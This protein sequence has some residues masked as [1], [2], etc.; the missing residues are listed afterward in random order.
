MNTTRLKIKNAHGHILNASLDRPEGTPK[1]YAVFGHCFTCSGSIA[2]ARNISIGLSSHGIAV[3]RFD[4]TGLGLSKGEFTES[5]FSGN[6]SDL[7]A[8][9]TYM[10][11][12]Y[13]APAILVG[14]SLGGAAVLAAAAQIPAVKAVATVGAPAETGH[15]KHLFQHQVDAQK[16]SD[17]FE[18]NVGGRP[19]EVDAGFVAD[20]DKMDLPSIIKTLKKPILIAHAPFDTV[21]G[22]E[23]A[24]QIFVHA[25][26]PKS[27]LSL[28]DADHLLSKKADSVYAG[29][30]IGCWAERYI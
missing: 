27:F 11:E 2:A 1:A 28:D 26:H 14:H 17:T 16:G 20:F 8:V 7:T 5:H 4:F 12:H 6:V 24:Q 3:L 15:V 13:E 22:I 25:K 10:T 29:N 21:V 18:I 19:F 23:N 30:V 9:H